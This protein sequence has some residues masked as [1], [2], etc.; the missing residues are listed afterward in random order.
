[1]IAYYNA[2]GDQFFQRLVASGLISQGKTTVD[3]DSDLL[4]AKKLNVQFSVVPT[5]TINELVGTIN[6]K[7]T[8]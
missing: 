6:L 1:M 2:I 5:G 8:L 3:P 4:G 7:T